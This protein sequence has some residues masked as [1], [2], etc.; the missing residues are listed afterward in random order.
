MRGEHPFHAERVYLGQ[1]RLDRPDSFDPLRPVSCS[2]KRCCSPVW[3]ADSAARKLSRDFA[4]GLVLG[5]AVFLFFVKFLN[6]NLPA[7][8][9]QPLLGGAGHLRTDD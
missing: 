3:R 5:L 6:V 8:W 1:R 4:I 9:L 2:R 7:G